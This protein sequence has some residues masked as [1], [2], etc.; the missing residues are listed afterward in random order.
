MDL[1][2][3]LPIIQLLEGKATSKTNGGREGRIVVQNLFPR[4]VKLTSSK[5]AENLRAVYLTDEDEQ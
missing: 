5:E 3:F 4:R 1:N 2:E